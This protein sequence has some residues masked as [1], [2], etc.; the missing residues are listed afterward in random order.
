MTDAITDADHDGRGSERFGARHDAHAGDPAADARARRGLPRLGRRRQRVPRLPRRHRRQLA[1]ARA[2]GAGGC[3]QR[4]RSRPSRTSRTTSRPRRSSSSPSGSRRITGAGDQGRVY[5]GNSG[6]EANEA[7]FKLA[8]LNQGTRP[9]HARPRAPQ[10]VPRPH[11]G[12]ARAH[13]QAADARGVRAAARRASS[14][15]TRRSRR[16]RR[17]IDDHV[18]ALFVEPIKG[19]AGVLDLPRRLPPARP[20]AHREARRA[21]DHRRDPDRRRPHRAAGSPTSTRASSPTRSRSRRASPAACRSARSSPSAGRPSCS[22]AASTAAPS[23]A[24]RSR[25]RPA[26][27]VLGEIE[28]ADLSATPRRRGEE[29]RAD[30]PQLRLAADRRGPRPRPAHRHRPDRRRGAPARRMPRSPT[31]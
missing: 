26:N 28:R 23:A 6:A 25:R 8:R 24:T 9:P 2:S 14:T 21:A 1:R 10:R 11:D 15:S 20:R 13:R 7:A 18:A 12:L 16:S 4:A 29:L 19:E 5:F 30:H 27:A 31:G 17:A 3:G 22:A